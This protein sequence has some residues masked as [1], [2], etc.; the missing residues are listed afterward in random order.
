MQKKYDAAL[1]VALQDKL[2]GKANG[3]VH[4]VVNGQYVQL[5]REGTDKIFVVLVEFGDDAVP[6]PPVP[7]PPKDRS[8]TDVTGPLHNEIPAAG[9]RRSTTAPCGSR[10]TTGRTTRTCTSTGWRKYYETQSSGRYSVEGDVTDWVKVPFNEALYGRNY[11]GGIVCN[12]TQGTG[13]R[14]DGR[15]GQ[16]P[17]R[18]GKTMPQIQDYLK[19]FDQ[20]DRY[21]IDGDGN[22]NEPD[23]VHRPHPDRPRGRRRGG[24]RPEPGHRRHLEP[25]LVR[26]PPGRWPAAA[27][28]S[29]SAPTAASSPAPG[30]E[31]PDRRVGR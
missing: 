3:K 14:R 19:T 22:F 2:K 21:D 13:P 16:G 24:R 30:P 10:T 7:D 11:C 29:T 25:P 6:G 31:Q 27:P 1:K 9:P 4:R 20:Q 8:T 12:T 26:Q 15:L 17:A 5:E 18:P 23:G 28:A